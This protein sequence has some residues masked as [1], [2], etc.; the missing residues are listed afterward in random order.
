MQINC[1]LMLP[2]QTAD[3]KGYEDGG[4]LDNNTHRLRRKPSRQWATYAGHTY[5]VNNSTYGGEVG[6]E[7]YYFSI[8]IDELNVDHK[9]QS[10]MHFTC[11]FRAKNSQ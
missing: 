7:P 1:R 6:A 2:L 5:S 3:V 4:V 10:F 11:S 9:N 8:E